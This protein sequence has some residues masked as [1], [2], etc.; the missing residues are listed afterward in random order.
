MASWSWDAVVTDTEKEGG[1]MRIAAR[2]GMHGRR[3]PWS[4]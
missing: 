4:K 1:F 2:D 3:P